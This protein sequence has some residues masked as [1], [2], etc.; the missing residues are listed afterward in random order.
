[1][2]Q[3]EP[4]GMEGLDIA[5][6]RHG[7][8]PIGVQLTWALQAR[9]RDGRLSP[10]QRLP[11]LRDLGDA[12]GINPNTV[13]AV[14]QRLTQQGLLDMQQG[15]GTF[16]ASAPP[17]PSAADNIAARAARQAQK[18]GI[19]PREIAAALYVAPHPSRDPADAEAAA[20]R[21]QLRRQITALEQAL[22]ELGIKHPGLVRPTRAEGK[23]RGPRLL[24]VADL[25][26]VQSGLLDRLAAMQAAVDGV[27]QPR[28]PASARKPATTAPRRATTATPRTRPA[29]AG[30]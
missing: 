18:H 28:R 4:I 8:V 17:A 11:G 22:A 1:M 23:R 27:E 13:R 2:P 25:E 24:D 6:D 12:L 14:Y 7:E 20:R 10:Q 21:Q 15:N 29:P 3:P 30:A 9:I 19:D 5:I 16:V 26:R